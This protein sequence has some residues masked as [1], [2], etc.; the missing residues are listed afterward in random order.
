MS[1]PSPI[2]RAEDCARLLAPFSSEDRKLIE[3]TMAVYPG[4]TEPKAIEMLEA[5]G[6]L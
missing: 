3:E 1:E 5:F 2:E 6:G 4:L